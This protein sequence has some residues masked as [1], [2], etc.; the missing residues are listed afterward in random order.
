MV[1]LISEHLFTKANATL[2]SSITAHLVAPQNSY[3][4][5]NAHR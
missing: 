3:S 1:I 4:R 2:N 5:I